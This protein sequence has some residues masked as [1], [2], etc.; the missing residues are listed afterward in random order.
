MNPRGIIA[1]TLLGGGASNGT[2]EE[3]FTQWKIQG[4]AG[5]GAGNIDPVRGTMNEGGLTG[6]RLG[7]HLPGFNTSAWPSGSPL[8]GFTGAG[9][10]WYTTTFSLDIDAD[11]DA[12]IGLEL[13][14]PAGTV[15]RV[16]VFVNGYQYGKYVPHIGPQVRFPF[17]PGV[18][19]NRGTNVLGLS[20]WAQEESGVAFEKVELVLYGKYQSGFE[21]GFA[22]DWS[23]LQP[24]W[25][26]EREKYV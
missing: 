13:S 4:N 2:A 5:G 3:T 17:P 8:S 12:P 22:R 14:T 1:A 20:V 26:E 25:T 7:W 24:G 10:R 11:L 23:E 18:L 21:G 16:Q 19:N 9:I 15:A 6:E